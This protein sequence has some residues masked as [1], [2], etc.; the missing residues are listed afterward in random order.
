MDEERV[1]KQWEEIDRVAKQ[2]GIKIFKG[3]EVEIDREGN[4]DFSQEFLAKFDVVIA[5][6]HR[7]VKQD[8]TPIFI[9]VC[10]NP[11]VDIIAHPTGRL[12]SQ[13]AGYTVD[14]DRVIEE[15]SKTNTALEINAYYDR[16]DLSD[17]NAKKAKDKGVKISIGSD[18][19]NV[20]ML[21][22]LRFGIGTAR[23]AWLEKDD[24]LNTLSA[25]E[26]ENWL[27]THKAHIS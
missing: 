22:F 21:N 20:G 24:I 1:K 7:A 19:H 5:A 6:F 23:R 25:K 3:I 8:L 13:R 26:L 17:I 12:I 10:H 27:K 4:L 16:L 11:H 14:I 9:K 15:A 18:A 2:V